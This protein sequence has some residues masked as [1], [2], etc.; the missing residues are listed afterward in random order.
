MS[1][2]A[3]KNDKGEWL[4]W[5]VYQDDPEFICGGG[6]VWTDLDKAKFYAKANDGH[7]AELVEA[8]EK[9]VVS[10][11]E[12]DML[13]QAKNMINPM[14]LLWMNELTHNGD[15]DGQSR[16]LRAYVNGYTVEKEKKYNVNVPHATNSYYYD[17]GGGNGLETQDMKAGTQPLPGFREAQ[18][19]QDE[20]NKRG[21]QDCERLEVTDDDE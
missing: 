7:V 21:L 11:E 18:F 3:V 2:F 12:A 19:T 8:P 20:I 6:S 4:G 15:S 17:M 16:L 9:V 13:E 14:H 1:L 5:E 10:E